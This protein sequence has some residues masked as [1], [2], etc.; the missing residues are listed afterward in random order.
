M[1]PRCNEPSFSRKMDNL[2]LKK[3]EQWIAMKP[4]SKKFSFV[5]IVPTFKL[6]SMAN[7]DSRIVQR[8]LT[9][10]SSKIYYN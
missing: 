8:G 1:L 10:V 4:P 5:M 7:V 9:K 2:P 3:F 6:K